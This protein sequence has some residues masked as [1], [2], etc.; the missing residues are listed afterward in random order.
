MKFSVATIL[1]VTG[2]TA[3]PQPL[4]FRPITTT[5][6]SSSSSRRSNSLP[7]VFMSTTTTTSTKQEED[8]MNNAQDASKKADRLR[9]M[10]SSQ[11][12][13]RGFKEVREQVEDR[14]AAEYQ[15]SFVKDLRSS[16]YVM[17]K[18]GV[19]VY[20]A[21]V[22]KKLNGEGE[23]K[24]PIGIFENEETRQEKKICSGGF[25]VAVFCCL[26]R[27]DESCVCICVF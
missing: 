1:C 3:F 9:M 24:R 18:D 14:M 4:A 10:K 7:V 8:T 20:L 27:V 16:N 26:L 15:S 25:M 21:K 13:R 23:R 19:K 5:V 6:S 12:H 17:E 22:R 11:F 2:V